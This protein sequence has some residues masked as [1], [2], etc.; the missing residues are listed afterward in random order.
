MSQCGICYTY[1][2][3]E[4]RRSLSGPASTAERAGRV[5]GHQVRDGEGR[6]ATERVLLLVLS[7]CGCVHLSHSFITT[8]RAC[9]WSEL[10]R[11]DDTYCISYAPFPKT[12]FAISEISVFA[13]PSRRAECGDHVRESSPSGAQ[14]SA[15]WAPGGA[16]GATGGGSDLILEETIEHA[17]TAHTDTHRTCPCVIPTPRMQP[18]TA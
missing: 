3:D 13:S 16:A 8:T 15:Q 7:A 2:R 14:G 6:W 1:T 18:F 11:R 5:S 10:I 12:A 4:G 17:A 9:V